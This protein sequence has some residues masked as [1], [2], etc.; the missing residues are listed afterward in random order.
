METLQP[1]TE[2]RIRDH[3]A[4][5]PLLKI[6]GATLT[7]LGKGF[8]EISLE[9]QPFLLRS[10]GLFHGGVITAIADS[11]GGYA[12]G[13]LF[14]TEALFLTVELK[15]NFLN[16]AKGDRLVTRGK[17]LKGGKTLTIVQTDSF[18]ERNGTPHP[19]ATALLTFIREIK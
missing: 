3:F 6:Y 12:C 8:A 9:P 10:G 4:A 16:P 17:V 14:E 19:V 13:T 18:I 11:A 5:Q 2:K 1:H 7:A 15:I